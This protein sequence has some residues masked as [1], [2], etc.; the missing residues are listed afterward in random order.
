MPRRQS[1]RR[2]DTNYAAR[3][4]EAVLRAAYRVLLL[5]VVHDLV[6]RF[7]HVVRLRAAGRGTV[8]TS[9]LRAVAAFRR[10]G[11]RRLL[12][13][14]AL[15][16]LAEH[17]GELLLRRADL[18]DIVAAKRLARTLDGRVDLRLRVG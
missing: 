9:G 7:D 12:L 16:R 11:L 18:A 5:A 1:I 4:P 8:A 14:E 13:I 10:A 2:I 6:V 17:A 15:A 3:S